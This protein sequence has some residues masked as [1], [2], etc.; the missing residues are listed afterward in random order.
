[1]RRLSL[2]SICSALAVV[3]TVCLTGCATGQ[4]PYFE[5]TPTVVGTPTGDA[6]IDA[7]LVLLDQVDS[8]TFTATYNVTLLFGNVTTPAT[9]TQAGGSSR[10]AVTLGAV[11]YTTDGQGTRT[12]RLDTGACTDGADPA[13]VSNTGVTPEFAFGDIAK[14]LRRDAASRIGPGVASAQTIAGQ[15][16]TCVEVPVTGGVKAYC[17]LQDGVVASFAGADVLID[18]NEYRPEADPLVAG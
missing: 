3:V 15:N 8:A 10:R 14:R 6:A 12:C 18:L 4:R 5:D 7:V 17:A 1:M 9:V 13:A 11:R 2:P 16:A